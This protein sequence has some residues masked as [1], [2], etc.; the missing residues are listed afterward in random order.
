MAGRQ[1]ETFRCGTDL[2]LIQVARLDNPVDHLVDRDVRQKRGGI[3]TPQFQRGTHNPLLH[4]RF[5]HRDPGRHRAGEGHFGATRMGDK[6]RAKTC[7]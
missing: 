6:H 1:V 2:A 4:R 3:L 7:A 5:P